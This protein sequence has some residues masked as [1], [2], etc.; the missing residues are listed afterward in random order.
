[1]DNKFLWTAH[2]VDE[3]SG[4]ELSFEWA[5][6]SSGNFPSVRFKDESESDYQGSR[7]G[8]YSISATLTNY[9]DGV[10][11]TVK[12]SI[13]DQAGLITRMSYIIKP[14]QFSDN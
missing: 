13:T 6:E 4:D 14:N 2:P 7:K 12:L 9:H 8:D 11:G 3:R 5:F 10:A 1:M